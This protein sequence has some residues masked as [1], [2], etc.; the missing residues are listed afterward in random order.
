[1]NCDGLSLEVKIMKFRGI[2]NVKHKDYPFGMSFKII[3]RPCQPFIVFNVMPCLG[4][5]LS[6]DHRDLLCLLE[7]PFQLLLGFNVLKR[8]EDGLKYL[9]LNLIS[10]NFWKIEQYGKS[11]D[12]KLTRTSLIS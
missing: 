10:R 6:S 3:L 5:L 4:Y 1:M 7:N 2:K 8:F 12:M 9:N 11:V